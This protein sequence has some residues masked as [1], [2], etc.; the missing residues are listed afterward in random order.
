[1]LINSD[2]DVQAPVDQVWRYLLDVPRMA[3][4]LPGTELTEVIDEDN[5]KGRVTIRMGPVSMRFAGDVEIVERDEA[6]HRAVINAAGADERGRGQAALVL[7]ATL[8]REGGGTRVKVAQDLQISGAAAQYG[9][10]MIS[11]VTNVLVQQFSRNAAEDIPRWVRG[12]ERQAGPATSASGLAIGITAALTALK[13]V[14]WRFF[15]SNARRRAA[16]G[17]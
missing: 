15:G 6:N 7:T 4:N 13:R 3:P 9:R 12:E 8:V 14:F 10:G 1:M 5:Y 11:D 17:G 16:M 2:F